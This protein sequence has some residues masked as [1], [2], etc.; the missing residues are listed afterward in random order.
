MKGKHS[1]QH[2]LFTTF[3]LL[4]ALLCSCKHEDLTVPK[5]NKHIRPAGD[6][7]KNNY[8][9]RLFYAALEY[10]GLATELNGKGPFTV[11]APANQAFNELGVQ[12]PEDF[13]KMNKDSL[14]FV[15]AYHILPMRLFS[16]DIPANG[17]DVRYATLAG[18]QLYASLAMFFPNNPYPQNYFTF[19]GCVLDN[20]DIVLANGVMHTLKKLQKPF[21]GVTV[22]AWLAARP[23]YSLY[24]A[25]LKKF[26]LW[27]ALAQPGRF[28]I[29]APDNKAFADAGITAA[30]IAALNPASYIGAR[31]FG[32]YI[33]YDR[34]Y[35]ITDKTIFQ[36]INEESRYTYKLKDDEGEF[37]LTAY[38]SEFTVSVA[39]KLKGG[40]QPVFLG[41]V[42]APSNTWAKMDNLCENGIVHQLPGILVRPDQALK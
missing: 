38:Y 30:D 19:G 13:K 5:P 31:L 18:K 39:G 37:V 20:R 33:L 23:A 11:L 35:F 24:V 32:A 15:M 1:S 36:I 4:A 3:V 22:Q 40:S 34:Q 8:D 29:F 26:G 14:R 12:L 28:T 6:F 17:V 7:I 21:P 25:G 27:D 42:T 41:S 2:I 16:T 9:F 10:T